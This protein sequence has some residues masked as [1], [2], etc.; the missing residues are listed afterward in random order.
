MKN[1]RLMAIAALVLVALASCHKT[2]YIQVIPQESSC[3]VSANIAKMATDGDLANSNLMGVV[4]QYMGLI[5]AGDAKQ[6]FQHYVDNPAD[7]GIDFTQPVY[8]FMAG[9]I[10][11]VT[12]RVADDDDV[13]KFVQM[14]NSQGLCSNVQTTDGVKLTQFLDDI[15]FAYNAHTMLMLVNVGGSLVQT[16]QIAAQLMKQ[17]KGSSFVETEAYDEMDDLSDRD[18]VAYT[19]G[20]ALSGELLESVKSL[21]PTGIRPVDI[22]LFSSVA[23][24]KGKA[25]LSA[26]ITGKSQTAQ[27]L[28]DDGNENFHK[29]EG[30]YLEPQEGFATWI[31]MGVKGSWLLEHL[32]QNP[33]A[34]QTLLML[35]RAI[36]VEAIIRSVD[37]DVA[38]TLSKDFDTEK[39]LAGADFM[40]IANVENTD[41]LKDVDYWQK[42]MKQYGVSM[43][44][45]KGND[46]VL[47]ASDYSLNWGV[48]GKDV[49]FAS[50][51]M[52][53]ANAT[54]QRSQLLSS[55]AKEIKKSQVYVYMDLESLLKH[56]RTGNPALDHVVS[57]LKAFVLKSKSSNS[58]EFSLE[59][60]DDS[61]NFLKAVL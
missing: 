35:E 21:L 14:L 32:K 38:I 57:Q 24:E 47:K 33:K 2:D 52:F 43:S 53:A 61:Q 29:I 56:A 10:T 27:K 18:I 9:D 30:R 19:N 60:K 3:V 4:N 25:V 23:F 44:R 28:L 41:F 40:L 54:A 34:K 46:Y 6:Q 13:E 17:D 59:L 51:K 20:A 12:M 55:R 36:D 45:T 42:T 31:A 11:G 7:L 39:G 5:T 8:F 15:V 22:E 50:A 26:E 58:V 48:D 1:F 37:G 16:R 49:Y